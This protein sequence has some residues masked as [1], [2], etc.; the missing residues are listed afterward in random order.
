[1]A[2]VWEDSV[3][4]PYADLFRSQERSQ[5][6]RRFATQQSGLEVSIRVLRSDRILLVRIHG[7]PFNL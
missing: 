1:M 3:Q 4:P 7:K 6:W 5:T 2:A